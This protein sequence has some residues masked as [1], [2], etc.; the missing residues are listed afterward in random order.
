MTG[1]AERDVLALVRD[2]N[3]ALNARDVDGVMRR[4]TADCVFENTSPRPDGARFTGQAAVR[5]FW[6]ELIRGSRSFCF[7]TEEE[8]V[9]GDRCVVRWRYEWEG[10]DGV[11]GHVRGVDVFRIADGL[12]AEKLAYVKG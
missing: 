6:E 8:I 5:G 3:A 4:M 1:P 2:F 12:I 11:R 9:T 10:L 7:T